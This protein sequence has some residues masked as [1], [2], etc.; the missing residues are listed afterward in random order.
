LRKRPKQARLTHLVEDVLEAAIQ[1]LSC[2][3]AQR[4]TSA[5]V[6][7]ATGVSVGS[8]YQYFPNK[9]AIL[10]RLQLDEWRQIAALLTDILDASQRAPLERLRT[11]TASY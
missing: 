5:R 8:V 1:V 11:A 2:E 9:E 10:F 4:F 6:A 3:G 7:E